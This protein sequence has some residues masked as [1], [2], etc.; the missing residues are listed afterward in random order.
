MIGNNG[1]RDVSNGRVMLS[2]NEKKNESIDGV[3]SEKGRDWSCN[4]CLV[5]LESLCRSMENWSCEVFVLMFK[6]RVK[7]ILRTTKQRLA[8]FL[9]G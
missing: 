7:I 9:V 3:V 8:R 5:D 2:K 4:F 1:A 6:G